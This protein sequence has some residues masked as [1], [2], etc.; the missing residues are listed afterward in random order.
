MVIGLPLLSFFVT[1]AMKMPVAWVLGVSSLVALLFTDV[2]LNTIPQKVLSGMDCYPL[3]CMPFF[4]L[5]GELM[6]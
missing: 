4:I 1:V 3:I 2:P 5:A 6:G